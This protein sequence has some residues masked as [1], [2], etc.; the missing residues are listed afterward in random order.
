MENW[1]WL[2]IEKKTLAEIREKAMK[3]GTVVMHRRFGLGVV[4]KYVDFFDNTQ[5]SDILLDSGIV[6]IKLDEPP[7]NTENVVMVDV[8]S[9]AVVDLI[10]EMRYC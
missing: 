4:Q 2:G 3:N 9:L 8:E 6:F 10:T 7:A 5:R 1:S